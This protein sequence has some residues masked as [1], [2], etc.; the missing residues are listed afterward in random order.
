MQSSS[1]VINTVN[2]ATLRYPDNLW[3]VYCEK[4]ALRECITSAKCQTVGKC[5]SRCH[6]NL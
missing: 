1:V 6:I 3:E 4:I 2:H 5:R